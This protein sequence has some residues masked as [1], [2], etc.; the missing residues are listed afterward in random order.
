MTAA[1]TVDLHDLVRGFRTL[2]G[3]LQPS[4]DYGYDDVVSIIADIERLTGGWR[5]SDA[6]LAEA[7]RINGWSVRGERD[8]EIL[9]GWISKH[10]WKPRRKI[11]SST[12]GI[13]VA[14][15]GLRW[16]RTIGRLYELGAP[17]DPEQ[18][19]ALRGLRVI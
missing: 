15:R 12:S 11:L 4:A 19:E 3:D 10:P 2:L 7:A 1:A 18:V 13:V 9:S 6:D 14:D 8:H 5:P 17:Q 16:V